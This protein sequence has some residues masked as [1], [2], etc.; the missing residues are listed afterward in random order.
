MSGQVPPSS[1]SR[2]ARA[3]D[4]FERFTGHE[5]SQGSRVKVYVP[6]VAMVIGTLDGV[7]YTA[8]RDGQRERYI[9]EFAKR[10]APILAASADGRQLMIVGGNYRMTELG[11]VDAS[12]RKHRNAR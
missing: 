5:A 6:D 10:D 8:I 1:R 3:A 4:L 7:L 2:V 9:H 12:D 11:I